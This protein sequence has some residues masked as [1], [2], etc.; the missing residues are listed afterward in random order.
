MENI[1]PYHEQRIHKIMSVLSKEEK[2][3]A[4]Y[5]LK[6]LGLSVNKLPQA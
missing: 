5:L 4:I 6:K 3:T 2:E 1:F